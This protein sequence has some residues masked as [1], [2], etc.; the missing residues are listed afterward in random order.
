[1]WEPQYLYRVYHEDG[2]TGKKVV[3]LTAWCGGAGRTGASQTK[4]GAELRPRPGYP[5]GPPTGMRS[6]PRR[7]AALADGMI[8][9]RSPGAGSAGQGRAG[10]L[11]LNSAGDQPEANHRLEERQ[12]NPPPEGAPCP[13]DQPAPPP[14]PAA[15]REEEPGRVADRPQPEE[16]E[17]ASHGVHGSIL[18]TSRRRGDPRRAVN[19][20]PPS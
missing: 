17:Q 6:G 7:C 12:Q 2:R 3:R 11:L 1:M 8:I 16:R 4:P 18:S 20:S 19:R 13:A 10:A 5:G 14:R 15:R 9:D